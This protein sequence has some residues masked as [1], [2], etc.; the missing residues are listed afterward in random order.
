LQLT[1]ISVAL[2]YSLPL[3]WVITRQ[4]EGRALDVRGRV[5]YD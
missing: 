1:G 5:I 3:V 2:I 4:T